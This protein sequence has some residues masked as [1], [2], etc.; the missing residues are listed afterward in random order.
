MRGRLGGVEDVGFGMLDLGCGSPAHFM[1][2]VFEGAVIQRLRRW[3]RAWARFAGRAALGGRSGAP[4]GY[5]RPSLTLGV[6]LERL[7]AAL[8]R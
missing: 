4:A 7:F 5:E 2:G 8:A 6:L 1:G 3:Q